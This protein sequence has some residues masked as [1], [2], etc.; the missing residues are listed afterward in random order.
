MTDI[1]LDFSF[2]NAAL[3]PNK[4]LDLSNKAMENFQRNV[5]SATEA[6]G[7]GVAYLS[8]VVNNLL[9]Y[10]A[11][12]NGPSSVGGNF[13]AMGVAVFSTI[14]ALGLAEY[15]GMFKSDDL[16]Q[17][18]KVVT[19]P[20]DSGKYLA[21]TILNLSLNVLGTTTGLPSLKLL[22]FVPLFFN[23]DNVNRK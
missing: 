1:N 17:K 16:P 6:R 4:A 8:G 15:T 18:S 22:S 11:E 21:H 10:G 19:P 5:S 3:I 14:Q 7:A 13:C 9:F 20:K 2:E 23:S 12:V